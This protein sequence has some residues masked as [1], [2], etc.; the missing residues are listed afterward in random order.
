[1]KKTVKNLLIMAAVLIVLGAAALLLVLLPSGNEGE[2]ENSSHLSS[3]VSSPETEALTDLETEDVKAVSV[4]NAEDSFTIVP[5]GGTFILQG[6]GEYNLNT[7]SLASAVRTLSAMTPSKSLGSQDNLADFGLSGKDAV[8]VEIA[9]GDGSKQSFVLGSPAG[10]SVGRYVLKDNEVYIVPDIPDQLYG[11]KF[12]YFSPFLYSVADRTETVTDEN[13]NTSSQAASDIL[14]ELTLSGTNFPEEVKLEYSEDVLSMFLMTAP[15]RA[16]SGN[17]GMEAVSAALKAPSADAVVAAGVT[18]EVLEEYGLS[19]P[20]AKVEFTMN[21]DSHTMAVSELDLENNRYLVLDDRDVIFKVSRSAVADWAETSAMK[22]R[23]SYIWLSNIMD[24]Q[25]LTLTVDGDMVYRFD[26]TRTLDE[27]RS[28]EDAPQYDLTVKNAGGKDVEYKNYQ[29]FYQ[30][31]IGTSVLSV[32]KTIVT[33]NGS[34]YVGV[35]I[36]PVKREDFEDE[37]LLRV[38]YSFFE[39][40]EGSAKTT[41]EFFSIANDRCVALLDGEFNGIVRKADVDKLIGQLAEAHG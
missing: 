3:R 6:Y 30:N 10:E 5:D 2:G 9:C 13:G 24:V 29:K 35:G 7:V 32:D 39:G 17:S 28:T 25:H 1:M 4:K 22:L 41:V 38:E 14:Y 16:E 21:S 26:I 34:D 20:F 18:D 40:T 15:V 23:M 33:D 12:G 19:E 27:E 31:L 8:Q 36:I 37:A 11:S